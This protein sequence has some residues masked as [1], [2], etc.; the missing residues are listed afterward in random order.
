VDAEIGRLTGIF[1]AR[2]A[3]DGEHQALADVCP[4]VSG[5]DQAELAGLLTAA[6]RLLAS[7]VAAPAG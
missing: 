7:S 3:E 4:L 6:V 2:A 5:T 1:R